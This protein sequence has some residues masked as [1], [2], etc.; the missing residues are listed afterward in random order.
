MS[1]ET[2]K[3]KGWLRQAWNNNLLFL[4]I[5]VSGL[6]GVAALCCYYTIWAHQDTLRNLPEKSMTAYIHEQ[7]LITK[8]LDSLEN[9]RPLTETRRDSIIEVVRC[10][11]LM[12]LR[13]QEILV[14]DVRQEMNN[15][16]NKMNTWLGFTVGL[17][18]VL[19]VFIPL[20][21]QHRMNNQDEEKFR[22]LALNQEDKL[23]KLKSQ[24]LDE[25]KQRNTDAQKMEESRASVMRGIE[26][27]M[28]KLRI[29]LENEIKLYRLSAHFNAFFIGV[30]TNLL[31]QSADREALFRCIWNG[32]VETFSI[33][34]KKCPGVGDN[35]IEDNS[36][37]RTL[38]MESLIK[39]HGML[40]IMRNH[41]GN[42]RYR[43]LW[44]L[45]VTI[46]NL[47]L[48]LHA[49]SN[50]REA[51]RIISEQLTSLLESLHKLN[52]RFPLSR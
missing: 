6:I 47:I 4:I 25:E 37:M 42:E 41:R 17:L 14:D 8:A 19:G 7:R 49:G 36:Y 13:Q 26:K 15:N 10:S 2:P 32:T 44:K 50:S 31:Y 22:T 23:K 51:W 12:L 28:S 48:D 35:R 33:L 43:D 20:A 29:D 21:L 27:D 16:I 24:I 39:L 9:I 38:L 11:Q 30:D 40:Y 18:S 34:C 52:F 46:E 1:H 45:S 3:Y 5:Y